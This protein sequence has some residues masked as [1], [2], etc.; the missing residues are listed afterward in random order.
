MT[1]ETNVRLIKQE[2]YDVRRLGNKYIYCDIMRGAHCFARWSNPNVTIARLFIEL[3]QLDI[4]IVNKVVISTNEEYVT[5]L[6]SI[7]DVG[8]KKEFNAL[9]ELLGE[10]Q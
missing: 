4:T 3:G 8:R 10:P 5:D 7:E 6:V 1:L 9:K 2:Q